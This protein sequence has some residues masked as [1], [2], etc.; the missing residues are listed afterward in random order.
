MSGGY[1][2]LLR[3]RANVADLQLCRGKESKC[4]LERSDQSLHPTHQVWTRADLPSLFRIDWK[5]RK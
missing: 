2:L 1:N 3:K 5:V 4:S